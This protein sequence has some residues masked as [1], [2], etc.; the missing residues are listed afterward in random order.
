MKYF[1]RNSND[2]RIPDD[3]HP[4]IRGFLSNTQIFDADQDDPPYI[5]DAVKYTHKSQ[6]R[7]ATDEYTGE[8]PFVTDIIDLFDFDPLDFQVESWQ[9]IRDLDVERR[10]SNSSRGAIFSAPTG[11]GKT[12][13]FLGPLYQ[14]LAE[15]DQDLAIV[16]Y[17]SRALL[18]DQ[19]GRILEHLYKLKTAHDTNLSVG[20]WTGNTPYTASEVEGED[21][22]FS[23]QHGTR[24]FKLADCWCGDDDSHSFTYQGGS[25]TYQLVCEND[26]A[27]SFSDREVLLNRTDI[28]NRPGPDVLLTTLESLELFSLKP[29]YSIIDRADT[30]VF[31]EV[32]LYTGLRG[33]HTANIAQNIESITDQ[34]LLWL[35][36]SAT[37]DDPQRFAADLFPVPSGRVE[38]VAPPD[39]DFRMD[40]EDKE[41]YYFLKTAE[42]GPGASSMAIQQLMLLG[43]S[44]LKSK[45][46]DRGKILSFIDSISQVNQKRAQL[47]DAD[48]A[49]ELW[50]HHRTGSDY[51]NWD[52]VAEEMDFEFVESSLR[53]ESVYSDAGF[54]ATA[55]AESDLLLSTSFLE[56]GIDVGEITIVTQY[57]TPWDLSSFIQRAGRAARKEDTDS[58]IVVFLS[59]L[60]Q[61]ANM[62]YR[63][64][65]F[66]GSEIR[67]PLK[68]DNHVIAWIHDQF[69]TFYQTSTAV[70]NEW[71][72]GSIDRKEEFL[73]RFLCSELDY[74]QYYE[75]IT[76]PSTVL[77]RE[78]GI[79]ITESQLPA[80]HGEEP[81]E[82]ADRVLSELR[83]DVTQPEIADLIENRSGQP[84][85]GEDLALTLVSEIRNDFLEFCSQRQA[86]VDEFK[87]SDVTAKD[88][89]KSQVESLELTLKYIRTSVTNLVD[90]PPTEQIDSLDELIPDLYGITS[91]IERF[92]RAVDREYESITLPA[93]P[94]SVD[95]V[96]TRVDTANR[97]IESEGLDKVT[98][99][100][101][102]IYYLK[103]TLT[104]L[105]EYNSINQ[106]DKSLYYVKY[107]LRGAYYYDRFLKVD[108]R[109]L[110]GTVWYVPPNYFQDSGK[111]FTVFYGEDDTSGDEQ[112]IDKL[113]QTYAPYRSEYQPVAGHLQAFLPDTIADDEGV[114]FSFEDIPGDRR[115]GM[116]IPDSIT[117][118]DIEDLSGGRALNIVQYCPECFQILQEDRCLRHNDRAF[119][120][121]HSNPEVE[122]RLEDQQEEATRGRATLADVTGKVTLTGVS[123]E[124]TPARPVGDE[125]EFIFTGEDRISQEITSGDRPLGF[126]LDTRGLIFDISDFVS[127]IDEETKAQVRD[128]KSLNDISLNEIAR[129]TAA[130]C[131]TQLVA[132]IGGVNPS[133]LF[134]GIDHK[135][136]EVYVFERSQGGQGIVDLVY[137]DFQTD[138]GTALN[139]LTHICYNP[140]TINE[141]IWASEEFIGQI[142]EDPNED[143]VRDIIREMDEVPIFP[144]VVDLIVDEVLSSIDR[145]AQLSNEE[146]ISIEAAYRIKQTVASERVRGNS[147]FPADAV[148]DIA[149]A[150]EDLD[151]VKSLFFSPDIDGCVENLH[152]AE[153]ISAHEQSETLS[154]VLLEQLREKLIER[155]PSED[156]ASRMIDREMLPGGE[157]DGTSVF[158]TL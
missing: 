143:I 112:S 113:A 44:L 111:Y 151:R 109:S 128:Y 125:N 123:L 40:H 149:D 69:E 33:A 139:A 60:T 85:Q 126:S 71:F 70:S 132:D 102:Q 23:N 78:F 99:K 32:H 89:V 39:S 100:R 61:D 90:S 91:D 15:E 133:M 48:R 84:V 3:V 135:A 11:F 58:H 2:S 22:F 124:I 155:V 110:E 65:R 25:S 107:L 115:D 83:K 145:A 130:H 134:Y 9:L 41:H 8:D 129:H 154:Y 82:T 42:D 53:L 153:C 86:L 118:D 16:V 7:R 56:V 1:D 147:E 49:N 26:E 127:D 138:P 46:G 35:G 157:I 131:F 59:D 4:L 20:V 72:S 19:L 120:K 140:Q 38:S 117:L 31:D 108:G 142:P 47:E 148:N 98:T 156:A 93:L 103:Q 141:R 6:D 45:S 37:V 28:R 92:R 116:I 121:I 101:K 62:F 136:D 50:R 13:A 73:E 137:K 95:D 114:R 105:D 24:R 66:L 79:D 80:L 68:T 106:N 18:Q 63:A 81:V 104:Q 76:E 87:D 96:V 14:L 21:A 77:S 27:H 74:E 119:G 122:T 54:D 52:R 88:E 30:I 34:S 146:G 158:L 51:S 5:T 17:P 67:T 43:H 75:F 57:R 97:A 12:E 150:V 152:L 29:N 94:M 64:D 55:T 36:S 10:S 144:A